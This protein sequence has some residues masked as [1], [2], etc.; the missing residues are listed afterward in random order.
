MVL[1]QPKGSSFYARHFKLAKEQLP[2][3]H[4][5]I[6]RQPP[7]GCTRTCCLSKCDVIAVELH[8]RIRNG[9]SELYKAAAK[10]RVELQADGEK[11]ISISASAFRAAMSAD[12]AAFTS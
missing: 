8:D 3:E 1:P 2:C 12:L 7:L 6:E 10:G 5:R 4:L 11:R 9:V